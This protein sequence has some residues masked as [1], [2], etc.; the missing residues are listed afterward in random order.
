M[1]YAVTIKIENFQFY[2]SEFPYTNTYVTKNIQKQTHQFAAI[3]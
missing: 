1:R 3:I 2:R